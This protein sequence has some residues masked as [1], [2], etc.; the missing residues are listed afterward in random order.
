ML[1]K[2]NKHYEE[3]ENQFRKMLKVRMDD[4]RL[5]KYVTL[6]FPAP[7]DQEDAKGPRPG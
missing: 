2:I 6:V 3:I 7:R 4:A 5:T 1:K